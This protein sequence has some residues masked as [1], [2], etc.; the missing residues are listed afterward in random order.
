M[1][2]PSRFGLFNKNNIIFGFERE[3]KINK[4]N[5]KENKTQQAQLIIIF[6]IKLFAQAI[7]L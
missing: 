3:Q 7:V 2:E 1:E 6:S 4:L 5:L